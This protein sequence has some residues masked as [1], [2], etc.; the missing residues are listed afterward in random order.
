MNLLHTLNP[1][2]LLALL[3]VG[4]PMCGALLL[5]VVAAVAGRE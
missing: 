5:A 1:V 3:V 4:L 2:V